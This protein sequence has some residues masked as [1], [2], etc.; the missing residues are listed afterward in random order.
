MI[1]QVMQREVVTERR[2][3]ENVVSGMMNG[4]WEMRGISVNVRVLLNAILE[5]AVFVS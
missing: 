4:R 5:E 1:R 2:K 3:L